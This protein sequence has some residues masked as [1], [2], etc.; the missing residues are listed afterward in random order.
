MIGDH[1]NLHQLV[2]GSTDWCSGPPEPDRQ[3]GGC[4]IS[5][6][7]FRSNAQIIALSY[8]NIPQFYTKYYIF[9]HQTS[10]NFTQL[11]VYFVFQ[12]VTRDLV[13]ENVDSLLD[14][15]TGRIQSQSRDKVNL[16][17]QKV[18]DM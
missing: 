17:C 5:L 8:N 16:S 4:N 13:L 15:L 1:H 12:Y 9:T 3:E 11:I 10:H 14:V 7:Q 18:S 2:F 6:L